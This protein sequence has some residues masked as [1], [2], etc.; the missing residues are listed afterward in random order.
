MSGSFSSSKTLGATLKERDVGAGV[1][2]EG[3]GAGA[4]EEDAGASCTGE[5]GP[6]ADAAE[7]KRQAARLIQGASER[8]RLWRAGM[9]EY[10]MSTQGARQSP[11]DKQGARNTDPRGL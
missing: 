5:E 10:G 3:T 6:T 9:V 2:E 1:A 7:G 11:A 8:Q 4:V